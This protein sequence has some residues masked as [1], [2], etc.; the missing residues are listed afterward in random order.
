MG[1]GIP[2]SVTNWQWV[3]APQDGRTYYRDGHPVPPSRH[4]YGVFETPSPIPEADLRH[5]DI[6]TL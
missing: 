1:G 2:A 3:E 6:I 5:F 4:R